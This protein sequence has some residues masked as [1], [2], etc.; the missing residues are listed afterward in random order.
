[1]GKGLEN[2]VWLN[3][4]VDG[5]PGLDWLSRQNRK[6]APDWRGAKLKTPMRYSSVI[7]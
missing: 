4:T 7:K 1:L 5:G 3:N 2:L 6:N